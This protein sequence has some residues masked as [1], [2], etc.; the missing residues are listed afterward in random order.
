MRYIALSPMIVLVI[1]V[2]PAAVAQDF[3]LRLIERNALRL[4]TSGTPP[5]VRHA[6]D[7]LSEQL[8]ESE[9]SECRPYGRQSAATANA[10][11]R[12]ISRRADGLSFSVSAATST[13]GGHYRNCLTCSGDT[14]VVVDGND[15]T[16]HASAQS[17]A[18]VAIIFDKD[19]AA[20]PYLIDVVASSS[21]RPTTLRMVGPTGLEIAAG[22]GGSYAVEPQA[23]ATFLLQAA[24]DSVSYNKGMCCHDNTTSAVTLDVSVRKAPLLMYKHKLEPLIAGGV[25]TNAYPSVG[26]IL[27]DGQMHCTATVVGQRTLLTAAHCLHGYE[28]QLSKFTF[29][30]GATVSTPDV[31]P[32][33]IIEF[34]YPTGT[35]GEPY[36]YNPKTYEDDIGVA[37][38]EHPTSQ[39]PMSLH[40][41]DPSWNAIQS[42]ETKLVF[43]GYGYDVVSGEKAQD[44]IKRTATWPINLVEN[45]RVAFYVYGKSTC[46]GDSGGPA[47][48][49][50]GNQTTQ[51]GITSTGAEDCRRGYETR[52]DAFSPWLRNRIK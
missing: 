45:R 15:T 41:G 38:L 47:F 11:V 19:A 22:E 17:V 7:L 52:V 18:D 34:Q 20:S 16:A 33:R 9:H 3:S 37:Y 49:V 1:M 24:A 10:D 42:G 2:V 12:E 44:G 5:I 25:K 21:G 39:P 40:R 28:T 23:G 43:V 26:A 46:K 32:I 31:P 30:L 29:L 35:D 4:E 8:S 51:V 36:S 48:L 13:Q 50:A 14:C 6:S 27:I